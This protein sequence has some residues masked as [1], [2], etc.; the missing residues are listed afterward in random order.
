[1]NFR[2]EL[3]TS[4]PVAERLLEKARIEKIKVEKKLGNSIIKSY[5]TSQSLSEKQ[6]DKAEWESN[7]VKAT[8]DLAN[9][10]EGPLKSKARVDQQEYQWRL[11]K[12]ALADQGEN[13]EEV[14]WAELDKAVSIV[15]LPK[16]EQ[17]ITELTA[18]KETLPE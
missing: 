3:V 7:L 14:V 4:R 5:T 1:M 6:K 11:D 18:H 8:T 13:P 10:P 9:S 12:L 2:L 15:A 16:V 17:L